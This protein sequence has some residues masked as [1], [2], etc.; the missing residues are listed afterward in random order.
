MKL[1][2]FKSIDLA[3]RKKRAK[4]F[5]AAPP[6]PPATESEIK[7]MESMVGVKISNS[8]RD[9]LI[10]FGGGNYGL[11]VIFCADVSSEWYLPK[12]VKEI[13]RYLPGNYLPI[14][15][16][17]TGGIYCQKI[18][19]EEALDQIYY[20]NTDEGIRETDCSDIFQLVKNTAF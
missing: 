12:Q 11:A 5:E 2:E 18:E 9:F 6:N 17:F 4:L 19:N 3:G 20:W 7:A 13:S 10:N 8:F 1:D 15:D 16:D 14:A